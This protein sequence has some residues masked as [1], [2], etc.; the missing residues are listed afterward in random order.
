MN[1]PE[2]LALAQK[3]VAAM[4]VNGRGYPDQPFDAQVSAVLRVAE[5]LIMTGEHR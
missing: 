5:F 2:A 4:A 3:T 1:R